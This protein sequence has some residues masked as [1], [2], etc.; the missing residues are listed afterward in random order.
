MKVWGKRATPESWRRA[1][2]L[3]SLVGLWMREGREGRGGDGAYDGAEALDDF[4]VEW[5]VVE[6]RPEDH[7]VDERA[8]VADGCGAVL[9]DMQPDQWFDGDES[10]VEAE[11]DETGSADEE[12]DERPP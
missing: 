5:E 10:F 12:R 4:V 9:E 8:E 3:V 7:A 1:G 2:G 6:Q 11:G